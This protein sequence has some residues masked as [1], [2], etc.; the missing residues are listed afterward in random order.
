M[1]HVGSG[2]NRRPRPSLSPPSPP[3]PLTA[4]ARTRPKNERR[5]ALSASAA[6]LGICPRQCV[7][8]G[9]FRPAA[10]QNES[11]GQRATRRAAYSATASWRCGRP[12][13]TKPLDIEVF[14]SRYP[15][16][17]LDIEES[18][19]RGESAHS[20]VWIQATSPASPVSRSPAIDVRRTPC[21]CTCPHSVSVTVP[22]RSAVDLLHKCCRYH[23]CDCA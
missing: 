4:L 20:R 22:T 11:A 17:N 16:F 15:G 14:G 7:V 3:P 10:G 19:N 21:P 6:V 5:W 13:K 1:L 18:G 9:R 8:A 23:L 12:T 2:T